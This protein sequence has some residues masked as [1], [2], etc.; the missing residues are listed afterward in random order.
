MVDVVIVGGTVVDGTGA[1]GYPATVVVSDGRLRL[2]RGDVGRPEGAEVVDASGR[3]VSPGFVDLHTHSDVSNLSDP[4][5]I[6]AIEQGVT[7]Q[8]VGLC[9][10]SAGPVS[11]ATMWSTRTSSRWRAAAGSAGSTTPS[12]RRPSACTA[13]TNPAVSPGQ[14]WLTTRTP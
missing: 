8:V 11:D 14:R 12:T 3:V 4:G 1:A 5:A 7:T 10:F 9:G 13:S 6:S 2:E